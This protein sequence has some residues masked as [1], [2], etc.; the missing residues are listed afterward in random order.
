LGKAPRR[1]L[2]SEREGIRVEEDE[3]GEGGA[4]RASL[5]V[6]VCV[7][8]SVTGGRLPGVELRQGALGNPLEHLLGEDPQQLPADVQGFIHRPVVVRAWGEAQWC[9]SLSK[10]TGQSDHTHGEERERETERETQRER[11]THRDR[12]RHTHFLKMRAAE[13]PGVKDA[14]I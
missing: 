1:R 12:D 13:K 3:E 8:A 10:L 2:V 11:E 9:W 4:I 5:C 14:V 7:G 6:C